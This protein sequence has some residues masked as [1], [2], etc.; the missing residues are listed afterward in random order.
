MQEIHEFLKSEICVAQAR[1]EEYA[2]R[3]RKPARKYYVGQEVW[4]AARNIMSD[5]GSVRI[6]H[7]DR[8]R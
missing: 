3:K 4:L 8:L 6:S 7:F 1:Q 5:K 2:N